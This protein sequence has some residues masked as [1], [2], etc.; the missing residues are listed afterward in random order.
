MRLIDCFSETFSYILQQKAAIE[1]GDTPDY[2]TVRLG[3]ERLLAEHATYS[4]G[5]FTR[6]QYDTA[7]FAMAAFVDETMLLSDWEHRDRWARELLQRS[8]FQT[9]N[10]GEEFFARL[11]GL[12]PFDP[13]ERDIREVYFYCLALGFVG[14]YYRP[15]DR[16]RLEE[17]RRSNFR[18]LRDG[19]DYAATR[20]E[21]E[22]FPGARQPGDEG[23]F[24]PPQAR[25]PVLY[26]GAPL[27]L[28]LI[29][30]VYFRVDLLRAGEYLL[31]VI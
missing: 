11:D 9:A 10:A 6:E 24:L 20:G 14:K 4:A 19:D 1:A 7:K 15:G 13:G 30:F 28:L 21:A 12:S 8:H 2:E 18:L 31:A 17:L 26:Y 25:R 23:E 22:L 29:A 16:A 5:G 27:L 3:V